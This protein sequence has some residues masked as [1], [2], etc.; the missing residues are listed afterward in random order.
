MWSGLSSEAATD[1][2]HEKLSMDLRCER[3][4][5]L[6]QP[7]HPSVPPPPMGQGLG[8][9][10]L[11][12][13]QGRRVPVRAAF[14]PCSTSGSIRTPKLGVC[15]TVCRLAAC[16]AHTAASADACVGSGWR[17]CMKTSIVDGKA[18]GRSNEEDGQ[19]GEGRHSPQDAQGREARHHPFAQVFRQ[20]SRGQAEGEIAQNLAGTEPYARGTRGTACSVIG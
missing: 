18:G 17:D 3:A 1:G 9:P 2:W 5:E 8:A 10:I 15:E 7:S 4:I 6:H 16:C 19:E 13:C 11:E 12:Q 20:K 14:A